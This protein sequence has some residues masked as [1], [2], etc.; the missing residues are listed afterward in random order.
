MHQYWTPSDIQWY[1]MESLHT[2]DPCLPLLVPPLQVP[3]TL[4]ME[5]SDQGLHLGFV[6]GLSQGLVQYF[7]WCFRTYLGTTLDPIWIGTTPPLTC[8]GIVWNPYIRGIHAYHQQYTTCAHHSTTDRVSGTPPSWVPDEGFE[9]SHS[10]CLTT[11]W[12]CVNRS[13]LLYYGIW[14]IWYVVYMVG[15]H[16]ATI[17]IPYSTPQYTQC[18]PQYYRLGVWRPPSWGLEEVKMTYEVIWQLASQLVKGQ[19]VPLTVFIVVSQYGRRGIR[20]GRRYPTYHYM[21]GIHS[22]YHSI[23]GICRDTTTLFLALYTMEYQYVYTI[24]L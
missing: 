2:G 12:Y 10:E 20:Q 8:S 16:Q 23:Q 1:S 15:M 22:M 19:Y 18:T 11:I 24:V 21:Y 5:T 7:F 4:Q 17:G 9:I 14:C 3:H 6:Q 13:I